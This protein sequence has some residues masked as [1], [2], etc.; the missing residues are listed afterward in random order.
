VNDPRPQRLARLLGGRVLGVGPGQSIVI[1]GP[2]VAAPLVEALAAYAGSRDAHVVWISIGGGYER[3]VL[4]STDP[5]TLEREHR[6]HSAL[7]ST[8]DAVVGIDAA[9]DATGLDGIPAER[10]AAWARGRKPGGEIRHRRHLEGEMQW[11]VVGFPCAVHAAGAD[12]TLD[13]YTD[14]VYAAAFCDRDGA[15]ERWDRQGAAQCRLVE[16]LTPGRELRIVAPGTALTLGIEGRTWISSA[17][18]TNLPDGEVFTG[19][20]EDSAEGVVTFPFP[21]HHAGRRIHGVRLV[22]ER[23]VVVEAHADDGQDVL[24]AALATD[25]GARR[26]GEIGIGTNYALSRFTGRTLLDEKIGGTVHLA[27]GSS[28]PETGG[29]NVSALHW[30]LVCDLRGGGELLLDGQA[31]QQSGRFVPELGLDL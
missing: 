14:L 22:F 12:M 10:Y 24:D 31:I 18:A 9:Q 16:R 28:Y 26:L 19:P 30:D 21:A 11:A 7:M 29:S 2:P 1:E 3:A 6:L 15:E 17:A 23:G 13:A 25:A 4:G 27:L 20:L 8:A 5:A